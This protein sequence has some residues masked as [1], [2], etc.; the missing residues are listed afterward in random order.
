MR[1]LIAL[2]AL[3]LL[4][5]PGCGD[6]TTMATG[7][8]M[9]AGADLAAPGGDMAKLSC[10]GVVSCVVACQG[11][12]TCAA[13]CEASVSTSGQT[14]FLGLAACLYSGVCGT[15]DGGTGMCTGILG[16][17]TSATCQQCLGGALTAAQTAG[18]PCNAELANCEAH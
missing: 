13:Q 4:V 17:D 18:A 1:N 7:A 15:G 16:S 6:D 11:N 9:A 8:D 2:A 3:V 5:A 10:A 12:A 14:A